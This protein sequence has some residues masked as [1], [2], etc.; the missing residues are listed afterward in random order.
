MELT[1]RLVFRGNAVAFG[2]RIVRPE[3]VPLEMPGASCI[4][5][6]G[7]RTVSRIGRTRFKNFASFE[8]ASTLAEGWFDDVKDAIALSNHTIKKKR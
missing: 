3:V 6:T 7:G 2:G 4:P 5:V 8:S 1:R